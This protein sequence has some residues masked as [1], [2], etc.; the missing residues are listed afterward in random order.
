MRGKI[1]VCNTTIRRCWGEQHEDE[2][3]D[4]HRLVAGT[5]IHTVPGLLEAGLVL[6]L[7]RWL[8]GNL[9]AREVVEALR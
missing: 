3:T 7:R 9:R 8:G 1:W 2:R 5:A 6:D 4:W